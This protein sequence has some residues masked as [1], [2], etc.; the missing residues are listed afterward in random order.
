MRLILGVVFGIAICFTGMASGQTI[1]L[2]PTVSVVQV[3]NCVANANILQAQNLIKKSRKQ[4]LKNCERG[5]ENSPYTKSCE[6]RFDDGL[7]DWNEIA[8]SSQQLEEQLRN[9][10][11]EF[12]LKE[13]KCHAD[14]PAYP[15]CDYLA[16]YLDVDLGSLVTGR[17]NIGAGFGRVT[18]LKESLN[19]KEFPYLH[20]WD[21]Y[22]SNGYYAAYVIW[23]AR[24]WAKESKEVF[25]VNV[26]VDLITNKLK[27]SVR[28]DQ[29][30]GYVR[31]DVNYQHTVTNNWN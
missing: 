15:T 9:V 22:P 10:Q 4:I 13:R 12:S 5:I 30:N 20:N 17:V 31:C 2:D 1:E 29:G 25:N 16:S 28:R 3:S 26:Y 8:R 23:T 14:A 6:H 18:N 11:F 21:R 7:D 19:I 24:P 27:A